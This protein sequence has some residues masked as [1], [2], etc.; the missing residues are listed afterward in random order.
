MSDTVLCVIAASDDHGETFRLAS[1]RLANLRRASPG[2]TITVQAHRTP[3][4]ISLQL[5]WWGTA[6]KA[7][8]QQGRAPAQSCEETDDSRADAEAA[9]SERDA[10]ED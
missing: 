8:V 10:R 4:D 5:V 9:S 7:T 6:P 1:A 3:G 2:A